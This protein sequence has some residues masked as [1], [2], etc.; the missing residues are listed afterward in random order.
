MVTNNR[1][2][3]GIDMSKGKAKT[4][5]NYK[6]E[7]CQYVDRAGYC[8]LPKYKRCEDCIRLTDGSKACMVML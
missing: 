6:K 1:I 5:F 4:K 8:H 2:T 7:Y 3:T